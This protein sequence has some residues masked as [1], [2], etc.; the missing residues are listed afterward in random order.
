MMIIF[1]IFSLYIQLVASLFEPEQ[2][3]DGLHRNDVQKLTVRELPRYVAFA[4]KNE[5]AT[6]QQETEAFI[7][8]KIEPGTNIFHVRYN[9]YIRAW[10]GLQLSP[11]AKTALENHKG[12]DRVREDNIKPVFSRS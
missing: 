1:V 4:T 9:N 7:K 11:E 5:T 3:S 8:S 6:D 10:Y 2:S 12:V